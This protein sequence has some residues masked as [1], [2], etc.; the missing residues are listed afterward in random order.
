MVRKIITQKL[1]NPFRDDYEFL[2]DTP[3]DGANFFFF[4]QNMTPFLRGEPFA[5]LGRKPAIHAIWTRPIDGDRSFGR[6]QVSRAV[7]QALQS[8]FEVRESI[9][10]S[11]TSKMTVGRAARAG[12][13]F[14]RH[15]FRGQILPLQCLLY[16]NR[17]EIDRVIA[18]IKH[19]VEAVYIDGIRCLPFLHRLKSARPQLAIVTDLDDLMSRRMGLLLE[20]NQAPSTG[21]MKKQMPRIVEWLLQSRTVAR[22]ILRYERNALR[23]IERDIVTASDV[24]VLISTADAAVLSARIKNCKKVVGIAPPVKVARE[25]RS[26]GKDKLRFVFVG[27]DALRQNELT[28]DALID[29]WQRHK[30]TTPLVI[31]GDQ[32]RKLSLP[33]HVTMPGYAETID[34][35]YQDG[36]IL[37]SPSYLAGGLKTKVL[38]AFAN[39]AAVIGNSV[40]F[41]GI[42]I[43]EYP[44]LIENEAELVLILQNPSNY[45]EIIDAAATHGAAVVREKHDPTT[46]AVRWT[47]LVAD[48]ILA[49][50]V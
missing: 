32:Q 29:I 40:T 11:L 17:Q 45:N 12:T 50:S 13:A 36:S 1:T 18:E 46:F 15:A 7:R 31:Y 23:V 39:G 26:I 41:E 14:I 35:I 22:S 16:S 33:A 20:L 10:Q 48:S 3:L 28:I 6:I 21:Y 2:R 43:G 4:E 37:L 47:T 42:D 24:V 44:L 49:R 34:D 38:E 5:P 8:R 25:P 9:L 19:D 27:S 30:I